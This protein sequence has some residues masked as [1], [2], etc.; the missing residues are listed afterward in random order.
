M[1]AMD[2]GGNGEV[3]YVKLCKSLSSK[4]KRSGSSPPRSIPHDHDADVNVAT[5]LDPVQKFVDDIIEVISEQLIASFSSM[6]DKFQSR[7]SNI[8]CSD[9][10][11]VLG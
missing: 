5:Q 11:A 2:Q 6:L 10:S 9:S 4:S 8:S 3:Q 1:Y 7:D